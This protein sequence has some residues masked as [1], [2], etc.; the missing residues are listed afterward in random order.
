MMIFRARKFDCDLILNGRKF[1]MQCR[2]AFNFKVFFY[3]ARKKL[4]RNLI[5]LTS[6]S[7]SGVRR[8]GIFSTFY[9]KNRSIRLGVF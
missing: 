3:V 8:N 4:V 1:I 6:F 7:E 5:R 2:L 9:E